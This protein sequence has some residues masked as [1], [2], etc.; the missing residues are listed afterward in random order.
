MIVVILIHN[1]EVSLKFLCICIRYYCNWGM[2]GIY[3]ERQR[4][5]LCRL[6]AI[7][8]FFGEAIISEKEFWD[9]SSEMDEYV[10]GKYHGESHCLSFDSVSSDHTLLVTYILKKFGWCSR[11]LHLNAHHDRVNKGVYGSLKDNLG[12]LKGDFFFVYNADHIWGVR[13]KDNV[14]YNV[15]SISGVRPLYLNSLEG[16]L[17]IGFIIPVDEKVEFYKHVTCIQKVIMG[18]VGEFYTLKNIEEYITD[19]NARRL[20]LGELEVPINVAV[21][22]LDAKLEFD[23]GG[24]DV[25]E[26]GPIRKLVDDYFEFLSQFTPS[27]YHDLLLKLEYIPKIILVLMKLLKK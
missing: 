22:I 18:A 13:R 8:A 3:Y 10:M 15:D 23:Y 19:I 27:R 25:G 24:G 9:Y 14:W 12:D 21:G 7:N 16:A 4:G 26:F 1:F 20:I 5:G 11:Y 17:N 2:E 6:H